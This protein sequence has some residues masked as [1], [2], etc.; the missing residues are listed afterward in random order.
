MDIIPTVGR[1]M[2]LRLPNPAGIPCRVGEPLAAQV[3]AVLDDGRAVNI[4]FLDW[5]GAHRD[6]QSVPVVQIGNTEPG[7]PFVTWMDYQHNMAVREAKREAEKNAPPSTVIGGGVPPVDGQIPQAGIIEVLNPSTTLELRDLPP[8]QK[9]ELL[10]EHQRAV[11]AM[12]AQA[13]AQAEAR[14][15]E[16]AQQPQDQQKVADPLV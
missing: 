6:M 7:G 2:H 1:I 14:K 9:Q 8:A 16:D 5:N 4:G 15:S 10:E 3:A 12:Q 13:D 11:A